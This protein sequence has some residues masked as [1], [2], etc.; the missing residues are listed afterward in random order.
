[1]LMQLID[2]I[3]TQLTSGI[4]WVQ[5][6]SNIKTTGIELIIIT[7]WRDTSTLNKFEFFVNWF[8]YNKVVVGLHNISIPFQWKTKSE[9]VYQI[10]HQ[11]QKV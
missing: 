1:M 8:E 6:N 9:G 11:A 3:I 5:I 10:S 2:T 4:D 7:H